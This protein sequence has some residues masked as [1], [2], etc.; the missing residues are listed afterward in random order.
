[1]LTV[2]ELR[3][4][5]RISCRWVTPP[6]SSRRRSVTSA[7]KSG[8]SRPYSGEVAALLGV[9]DAAQPG[10]PGDHRERGQ[11]QVRPGARPAGQ[12]PVDRVARAGVW[13]VAR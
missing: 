9:K 10:D 6:G 11:V 12:Q 3:L 2:P 1:M 5:A 13:L 7:L 4:S 8:P